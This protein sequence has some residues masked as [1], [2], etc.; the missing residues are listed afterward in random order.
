M[1]NDL[2]RRF[3]LVTTLSVLL[4]LGVILGGINISNFMTVDSN[5]EE[6][7]DLLVNFGGSFLDYQEPPGEKP[8]AY[9]GVEAPSEKPDK[10]DKDQSGSA[11]K[12]ENGAFKDKGPRGKRGNLEEAPF[13]T[14]YFTVTFDESGTVSD[15]ELDRISSV[16]EDEALEM[17]TEAYEK[18]NTRGYEGDLKYRLTTTDDGVK[19]IFLDGSRERGTARTFLYTSLVIAALAMVAVLILVIIFSKIVTRPVAES[20]EKQKRFI[21]DASHEIKT[22]IAIIDANNEVIEMENG[23]SEWTGS[24]RNQ[25]RRLSSLTEKL[26]LLSRMDEEGYSPEQSDLELDS[27]IREVAGTY[28]AVC[29]SCGKVIDLDLAEG[30]K[31]RGNSENIGR[32]LSLMIDNAIKY[33][34][35]GAHINIRLTG[36]QSQGHRGKC[37]LVLSNPVDEIAQGNLDVL[38]E[39][40]YRSDGSRSSKTGGHG[41][42]LSVVSAIVRSHKGRI[43]AS[44]PDGHSIVFDIVL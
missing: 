2:R 38:F 23:E 36:K 4:V 5:L 28:D 17:A 16:S 29:E 39:R 10:D 42:G 27:L 9:E 12:E 6:R 32:M 19:V 20:Y 13:D 43:H 40:F 41:I 26:V 24:I 33:S 30:V 7:M 15:K 18:G 11:K 37:H 22:P 8:D 31:I 34:S 25:T 35:E 1:I 14:R 3:I 44:S 21:T